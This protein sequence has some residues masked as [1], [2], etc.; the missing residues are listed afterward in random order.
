MFKTIIKAFYSV[1]IFIVLASIL[2]ASWTA[3]SY[4]SQPSKSEEIL[5]V[6]KDMYSS[7]KSVVFDFVDLTNILIKERKFS[8]N[9]ENINLSTKKDL[10]TVVEDSSQLI[11]SPVNEDNSLGIVIEP[12]LNEFGEDILPGNI[13]E[14]LVNEEIDSSISEMLEGMEMDINP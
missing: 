10:L 6:I 7:Q 13:E 14:P 3:Y 4:I 2:L 9:N 12:S 5:R 11:E 8:E 1:F